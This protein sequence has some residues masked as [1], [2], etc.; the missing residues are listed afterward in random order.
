MELP[1]RAIEELIDH[2]ARIRAL[3]Q[4]LEQAKGTQARLQLAAVLAQHQANLELEHAKTLNLI[5]GQVLDLYQSSAEQ[6]YEARKVFRLLTLSLSAGRDREKAT[7]GAREEVQSFLE[8]IRHV[9]QAQQQ[10]SLRNRLALLAAAS[11]D[12]EHMETVMLKLLQAFSPED[13]QYLQ[14]G[15]ARVVNGRVVDDRG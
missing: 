11:P 1:I 8:A 3:A 6:R 14:E 9:Q 12:A 7:K 13:A 2:A 4:L 5:A 15:C 10:A